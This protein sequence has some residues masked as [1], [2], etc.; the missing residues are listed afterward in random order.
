MLRNTLLYL[1]NQ[2]RVFKFVRNNRLAKHFAS[3]FVAGETADA[4]L[5]RLLTCW[6]KASTRKTKHAQRAMNT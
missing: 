3:R 1:S 2:P 6:A 4:A 5:A